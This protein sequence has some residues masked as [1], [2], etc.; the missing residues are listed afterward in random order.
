MA[1]FFFAN[2]SY[3]NLD[4]VVSIEP[5]VNG[6]GAFILLHYANGYTEKVEG[7]EAAALTAHIRGYH[8]GGI[9]PSANSQAAGPGSA[10]DAQE[11]AQELAKML[12][13]SAGR[14]FDFVDERGNSREATVQREDKLW[15]AV[16]DGERFEANSEVGAMQAAV[17]GVGD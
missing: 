10:R 12:G 1:D 15:V 7:D 13:A 11:K 14:R 3:L 6:D 16:V 8:S 4:Y 2:G 5:D 17:H 9:V